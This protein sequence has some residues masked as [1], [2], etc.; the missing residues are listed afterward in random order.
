MMGCFLPYIIYN[1]YHLSFLPLLP[2][3][4]SSTVNAELTNMKGSMEILEHVTAF[5]NGLFDVWAV[6]R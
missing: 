2:L 3:S 5:G 6:N 4:L 1:Y